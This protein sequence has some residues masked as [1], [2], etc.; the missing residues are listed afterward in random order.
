MIWMSIDATSAAAPADAVAAHIHLAHDRPVENNRHQVAAPST[1][2]SPTMAVVSAISGTPTVRTAAMA[3]TGVRSLSRSALTSAKTAT[4]DRPM[5]VGTATVVASS[6]RATNTPAMSAVTGATTAP[7]V[8]ARVRQ[9]SATV[10]AI[11]VAVADVKPRAMSDPTD[12][13]RANATAIPAAMFP[14]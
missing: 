10:P 11:T 8:R 3:A 2:A 9:P 14:E 5:P 1:Y 12:H 7:H 4:M 13:T 6:A